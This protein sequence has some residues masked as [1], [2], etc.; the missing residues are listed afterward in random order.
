MMDVLEHIENDKKY[1]KD[2]LKYLSP[3][4]TIF[5]TVPAFMSL[6][7]LHDKELKHFRRYN[8][9]QLS[10]VIKYADLNETNWSYFYFS[11][12]I[13]RLITKNQTKNLGEW[14]KS[15]DNIIK[16]IITKFLNIDFI[17]LRT[18]SKIGIHVPGLS[19]MLIC[20]KDK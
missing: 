17:V 7:S 18:L 5:I 15:D 20:K 4:G 11:L 14:D 9:D 12:I 19:L 16:K 2:I 13:G 1:L 3:N 6:Y 10:E 8:H